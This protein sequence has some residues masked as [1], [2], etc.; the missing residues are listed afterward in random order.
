MERGEYE[1]LDA[2]EDRM[3]WFA[4][5]QAQIVA[6][7]TRRPGVADLPVLDA[8]CGTGGLLRRL[9]PLLAPRAHVGV[10]IASIALQ[11]ARHKTRAALAAAS[12]AALP[13]ADATF[14]ALVSVDVL[15]HRAV[16]PEVALGE[17][18][19]VLAPGGILVLNLPAHR[20]LYSAHDARVHN[21]HRFARGETRELLARSGFE[22]VE[23]FHWN[24]LPFPLLLLQRLVLARRD[25]ATASSDVAL[26]APPVEA[27]M[28]GVMAVERGLLRAGLRFPVG[29]SLLAVG[30]V[31]R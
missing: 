14:G 22:E 17:F 1:R 9:E 21:A 16:V 30:A 19:R 18:R 8:G 26:F 24:S 31:P 25:D 4:A 2:V 13:F 7:L 6:A 5:L 15:C 3:W 12:V 29:G 20:W 23:V 11:R 28:R 27:A 10:D